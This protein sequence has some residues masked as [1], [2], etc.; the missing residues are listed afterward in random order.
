MSEDRNPNLITG[1]IAI[2]LVVG[3]ALFFGI[4]ELLK[5]PPGQAKRYIAYFEH[6][7]GVEVDDAVRIKGR[8]AGRVTDVQIVQH[9][10]KAQVRVEFEIS[11]GGSSEWLKT[12]EIPADSRISI[13]VPTLRGRPTLVVRI[14]SDPDNFIAAGGEW[15]NA[16]GAAAKDMYTTLVENFERVDRAVAEYSAFFGDEEAVAALKDQT[17]QIR[18]TLQ[19][20]DGKL[21]MDME[22]LA[23]IAEAL[24]QLRSGLDEATRSMRAQH[25]VQGGA[26]GSGLAA[27]VPGGPDFAGKVQQN[28]RRLNASVASADSGLDKLAEAMHGNPEQ[29]QAPDGLVGSVQRFESALVQGNDQLQSAGLGKLAKQLRRM[30][31]ELRAST[32][33]GAGDPS[34]FGANLPWRKFRRY[35]NGDSPLPGGLEGSKEAAG[36]RDAPQGTRTVKENRA[37]PTE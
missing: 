9:E 8:L 20:I 32:E 23:G 3:I 10:G 30:S 5:P 37:V 13:S 7:G 16:Q 36:A 27:L 28:I 12:Q 11:P 35:Y 18:E 34:K 22:S 26:L 29:G 17:R 1:W 21:E 19:E 2:V 33:L 4:R 14:G 31:A 15:T 25:E 6:A 24:D